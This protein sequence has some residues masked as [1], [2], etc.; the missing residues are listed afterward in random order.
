MYIQ[1]IEHMGPYSFVQCKNEEKSY[2]RPYEYVPLL[3]FKYLYTIV[4]TNA[5][6]CLMIEEMLNVINTK[7]ASFSQPTKKPII[8]PVLIRTEGPTPLPFITQRLSSPTSIKL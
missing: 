6:P 7:I 4:I 3:N 8:Q 5:D 2:V 1:S